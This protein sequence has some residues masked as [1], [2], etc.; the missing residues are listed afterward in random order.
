MRYISSDETGDEKPNDVK[1][2]VKVM[3]EVEEQPMNSSHYSSKIKPMV[4]YETPK[5]GDTS[6]VNMTL[7]RNR[8]SILSN[9]N[10][11]PEMKS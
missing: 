11:N 2:L 9:L 7:S 8:P 4:N 5:N 3:E 6:S 1:V 10:S